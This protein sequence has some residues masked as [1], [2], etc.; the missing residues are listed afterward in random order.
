MA[1]HSIYGANNMTD[2]TQ[3]IP[4]IP[5]IEEDETLLVLEIKAKEI[6]IVEA[7]EIGDYVTLS[8]KGSITEIRNSRYWDRI[9]EEEKDKRKFMLEGSVAEVLIKEHKI[10]V[11]P[12]ADEIPSIDI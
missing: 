7:L 4:T 9:D 8:V 10:S 5:E 11:T 6:E 3:Q 1:Y 12:E 2:Q